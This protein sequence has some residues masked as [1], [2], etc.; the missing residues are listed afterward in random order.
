MKAPTGLSRRRRRGM[1]L[2][3][4]MVVM[5]AVAAMLGTC[6]VMM[7]LAM[8]LHADGLA[9]FERSGTL[10]RLSA[11]FREDVHAARSAAMDGRTLRLTP[12]ADQLI[13]YR[14]DEG[15][16]LSRVV[17]QQGKDAAREPYRSPGGAGATFGFR[18][19][20]GRRFAVLTVD[21][22]ARR[23]RID[24]DRTASFEALVGRNVPPSPQSEG[25]RP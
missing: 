8:R 13:E 24:P 15:G 23:D 12:D 7:G 1:T 16:G 19:A 6:A 3:E 4:T 18:E 20:D 14:V 9:A 25:G 2:V 22:R 10:D 17:V 21:L 5:T 11:R